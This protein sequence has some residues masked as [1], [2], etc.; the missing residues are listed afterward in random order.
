MTAKKEK[1]TTGIPP[2]DKRLGGLLIG[3]NVL[4]YDDAGSLAHV[5]CMNFMHASGKENKPFIYVSFDRSPKNLLEKMG[6]LSENKNLTILD[7]F[8]HGKGEGAG[9]FLKFYRRKP[10]GPACRIVRVEKPAE[11]DHL[12]EVLYGIHR[13]ME[14]DVRFVFE[15][16]TGMQELWGGEDQIP[17]F[18]THT[19]PRLYELN[20]IAY[21][22]MEKD[23]HSQR[24][25]AG[26]NQIAQVAMDLSLKRGKTA[27][28]IL[29]AENRELDN[30][31]KPYPF[32]I[33]ELSVA[34]DPPGGTPPGRDL[35]GRV[36]ALRTRCGISQKDLAKAVGVTP[37]TISQVESNAIFPS[38]PALYRMAEI[39]SV[40]MGDFFESAGSA[41]RSPVF[42][43]SEAAEIQ[44]AH[45][46]RDGI[47]VKR[48]TPA[49]PLPP[50]DA[51]LVEIP[52]GKTLSAH[53]LLH[54]GGEMGHLLAGELRMRV[55]S[56]VHGVSA[57]D[58]ISLA[59]ETPLEWKN[60]GTNPAK[61]FWI[62]AR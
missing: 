49:T 11:P 29:K 27:L 60:T 41:A 47:T 42:P 25:R 5:F 10:N 21:W 32:W 59:T 37:S 62:A 24:L 3:D 16:L 13:Q 18:Y 54:K 26:I 52:P 6:K 36:K 19:C 2:L 28:S 39:L 43:S 31:N 35:G 8:T 48:L 17:K 7:C 58:T 51:Y 46:T 12:L 40:E 15:S 30:L 33:K 1:M 55:E 22:I 57:G 34:F 61:L 14:G 50:G 20:T 23:A 9:V 38:L 44:P 56:G 53:F 45:L 4:L